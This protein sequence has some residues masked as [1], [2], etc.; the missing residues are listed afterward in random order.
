MVAI[1]EGAQES[2]LARHMIRNQEVEL[3]DQ[4]GFH[5][6]EIGHVEHDMAAARDRGVAGLEVAL[7][8][9]TDMEFDME[10]AARHA[11]AERCP[12]LELGLSFRGEPLR[13]DTLLFEIDARAGEPRR[14]LAPT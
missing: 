1:G 12:D 7:Q 13:D 8:L 11:E 3:A 4:R 6:S 9:G 14:A 5:G 10:A 2:D